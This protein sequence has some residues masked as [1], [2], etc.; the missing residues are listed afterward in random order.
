MKYLSSRYLIQFFECFRNFVWSYDFEADGGEGWEEEEDFV[1][2]DIAIGVVQIIFL[3]IE[4]E[5]EDADIVDLCKTFGR[6]FVT[7]PTIEQRDERAFAESVHGFSEF[8]FCEFF[9][10]VGIEQR[11]E[12]MGITV[13][14]TFLAPFCPRDW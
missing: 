10:S 12:Q 4:R 6:N 7:I 5:R 3:F 2:D 13:E 8:A 14:A 11:K 1:A 9:V